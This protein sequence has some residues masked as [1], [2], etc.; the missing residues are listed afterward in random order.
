MLQILKQ[1]LQSFYF[2]ISIK[3]IVLLFVFLI[4]FQL[5]YPLCILI[6]VTYREV[7]KREADPPPPKDEH[8]KTLVGDD[9][10]IS[11]IEGKG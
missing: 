3:I 9:T 10:V 7:Y 5:L 4:T 6:H 2:F 8:R 11:C 1:I